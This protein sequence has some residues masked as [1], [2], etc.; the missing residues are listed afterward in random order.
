MIVFACDSSGR[1]ASAA[2][3]VDGKITAEKFLDAGLTHSQ[4]LMPL[5][6]DV[7]SQA[8]LS[9]GDVDCFAVSAGPG[10]FT[11]LRIGVGSVKGMAFATGARCVG[12]PTL[13]AY[14]HMRDDFEG[15]VISACD[16]RRE[17]VYCASFEVR[18]GEV[19]RVTDDAVAEISALGPLLSQKDIL[20]VGDAASVCYNM[21]KR[22]GASFDGALLH[23]QAV[24][25]CAERYI[26]RGETVSANDLRPLYLQLS[27][28]ERQLN[29]KRR[30]NNDSSCK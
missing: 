16:A 2:I 15:V 19:R 18:G 17:R 25:R 11:G 23:A 14:A 7:F 6:A 26:L 12:V 28:A 24:A 27:Q 13:E 4:T 21:Y 29:M 30:K 5:C 3:T 8:G 1:A 20:F 22:D 10:S 9:P